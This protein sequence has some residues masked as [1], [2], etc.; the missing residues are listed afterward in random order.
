MRLNLTNRKQFSRREG[1]QFSSFLTRGKTWLTEVRNTQQLLG[2]VSDSSNGLSDEQS[3]GGEEEGV[4]KGKVTGG[5]GA[6]WN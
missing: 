6:L 2:C 3:I 5:K 4:G 1:K